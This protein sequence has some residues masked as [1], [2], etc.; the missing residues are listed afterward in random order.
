M[1]RKSLKEDGVVGAGGAGF[2][3]YVKASSKA[4]S[5]IVNAA[6]CEPLL[7]KDQTILSLY[8]EA[9]LDGARTMMECVSAEKTFIGIK[10]KH[11][12]LVKN[13]R[14]LLKK[15]KGMEIRELDDYYPAGDEFCLVRDV[16]GKVIPPGGLPLDVGV[17][18]SNVETLYNMA[19]RGPV[20]EKFLSVTGAV[21]KPFTS[22][23]PVGVSF[24]ELV[25]FAGGSEAG[26]FAAI[27][28]GPMMGRVITDFSLPV[29]KTSA[30]LIVLPKTHPL[31]LK[32]ARGGARV[33]RIGKSACD[34]C[35]YCT[36]FCPRYLLGHKSNPHKVMRGLMFN[37]LDSAESVA[38]EFSLLC[39][40]CSL[41]TLYS[42][43]ENLDPGRI[44][45][46]S[47]ENLKKKN[48]SLK[49]SFPGLKSEVLVHPLREE[50]KTPVKRLVAKLGLSQYD[51]PAPFTEFNYPVENV[52]IMLSQHIGVP[53]EA[54][55]KE[56]D[57]VAKGDAVAEAPAD[58][59]GVSV[60]AS[61]SGIVTEVNSKHIKIESG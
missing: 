27:D 61:I 32:K 30:G 46:L 9:V 25:D 57:V 13:L 14:V 42:C 28:G 7:K 52:K 24:A 58:K 26:D 5:L 6:E 29:T 22:R 12:S 20:T 1:K 60:H 34:Q 59:L 38:S 40:E 36:E 41:C 56:G 8:P 4:G 23:V 49:S 53:A 51:A 44:C 39:S 19:A 31:I 48:A 45:A 3:A 18:V 55:V 16:T 17:V 47:K 35:S 15:Y 33:S 37:P 21:R 54:A 2:P 10:S 11:S 50:R 43:P